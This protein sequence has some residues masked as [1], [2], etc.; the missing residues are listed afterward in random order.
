MAGRRCAVPG[1]W[2]TSRSAVGSSWLGCGGRCLGGLDQV[3]GEAVVG[4]GVLKARLA[5]GTGLAGTVGAGRGAVA[6]LVGGDVQ[7]GQEGL[8]LACGD[9]HDVLRGRFGPGQ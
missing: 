7:R 2:P 1:H 4:P 3:S 8:D 5:G 9:A 6:F